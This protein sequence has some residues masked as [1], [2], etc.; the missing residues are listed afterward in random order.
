MANFSPRTR[1]PVS[2]S[3]LLTIKYY[4][5]T[6][7]TMSVNMEWR[8]VGFVDMVIWADVA[9]KACQLLRRYVE[10]D[11]HFRVGHT[12]GDFDDANSGMVFCGRKKRGDGGANSAFKALSE[13]DRE[14]EEQSELWSLPDSVLLAVD[15]IYP[16]LII[17]NKTGQALTDKQPNN[18]IISTGTGRVPG[19]VVGKVLSS[20]P[21][22]LKRLHEFLY[23]ATWKFDPEEDD[24]GDEVFLAFPLKFEC[25]IVEPAP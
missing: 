10:N 17:L 22:R 24:R 8:M 3:F 20:P 25:S 18:G 16:G 23:A 1:E 12:V 15:D 21:E 5:S 2:S 4:V 13:G 6:K 7:F 11:Y 9:P 19:V 14:V